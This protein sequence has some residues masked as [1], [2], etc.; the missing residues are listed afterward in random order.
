MQK[1]RMIKIEHIILII[2][3]ISYVVYCSNIMIELPYLTWLDQVPLI[4]KWF[5][6]TITIKDL[7]SKYGE[8]G[9]FAYNILWIINATFFHGSTLFD[10]W[11]NDII[12]FLCAFL[13]VNET[14]RFLETKWLYFAITGELLFLCSFIQ[15]SSGAMETQV[16]L[17]ILFFV[18]TMCYIEKDLREPDKCSTQ[19]LIK[20]CILIVLS[21]NVFGTLYS[22][23]GVPLIWCICLFNFF[24]REKHISRTE[25]VISAT[26]VVTIPLYIIEYDLTSLWSGNSSQ[27]ATGMLTNFIN[28][29]FQIKNTIKCIFSWNA[30]GVLGWAFHEKENYSSK[31]WLFIGLIITII[32]IF[33]IVM[34]F[35]T[36]MYK[37]TWIP[38]MT[39][40]Y[41]VGICTMVLLGRK[42]DFEWMA[43]EWYSTHIRIQ[44][45]GAIMILCYSSRELVKK[46]L[47]CIMAIISSIGICCFII[48]GDYYTI[49]RAPALKAYYQNMQP[50]LFIEN[51]KD[52]PVD[53]Y[54]Q[55]PLLNSSYTTWNSINILK[56]YNL[57]IYRYYDVYLRYEQKFDNC[58][59]NNYI[60]G[61]T[62]I[63][64]EYGNN[65]SNYCISGMSNPELDYSWSDGNEVA[66]TINIDSIEFLEKETIDVSM[67]VA[68]IYGESQEIDIYI[69]DDNVCEEKIFSGGVYNFTV[70][71]LL[72]KGK[73]VI[74]IILPDAKSPSKNGEK[75]ERVL[76][77]ALKSISLQ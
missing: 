76:G 55:T 53:E 12:V 39:I 63:F 35:A 77:I 73:N 57:S 49:N 11:I 28:C 8:H 48:V 66:V 17:G 64:S 27:N 23:A 71:N 38:L 67:D 62:I 44:F 43:N 75:D 51:E 34:F 59:R 20:D 45:A 60:A 6:G 14:K 22:F 68:G 56:K 50:Y 31:Q 1:K 70:E 40:V 46:R 30:N 32:I 58:D 54:G 37:K 15:G 9:M 74:K 24:K 10:V 19:K 29:I 7:V 61:D 47:V 36:Q 4:D 13:L 18:L 3:S 41:S 69:N 26:Y 52:M 42:T 21:I 33:S 16:R 65:L 72:Q 2:F 5:S 25:V